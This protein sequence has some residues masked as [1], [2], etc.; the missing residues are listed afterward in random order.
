MQKYELTEESIEYMGRTLFRI[1]A[2][3]DFVTGDIRRVCDGD[4]GGYVESEKN[5]SQEGR[6]WISGDA[7]VYGDVRICGNVHISDNT[8]SRT[9]KPLVKGR[10]L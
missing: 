7:K 8:E 9:Q 10:S 4:L 2:I 3:T 6:A 5:L 1:R